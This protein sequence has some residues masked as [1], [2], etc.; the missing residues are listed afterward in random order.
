[1]N[2][3][4]F[5]EESKKPDKY[6]QRP[7]TAPPTNNQLMSIINRS[8]SSKKDDDLYQCVKTALGELNE[9]VFEGKSEEAL[10]D[11]DSQS[12]GLCWQIGHFLAFV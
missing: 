9:F 11:Q 10:F 7:M 1:M 8:N 4:E 2:Y 3:L 12:I 5:D 6:C